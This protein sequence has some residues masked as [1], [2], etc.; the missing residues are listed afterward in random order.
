M[1][2]VIPGDASFPGATWRGSLPACARCSWSATGRLRRTPSAA[3]LRAR[4]PP[5][6]APARP[7]RDSV[8]AAACAVLCLSPLPLLPE[9]LARLAGMR[10][11]FGTGSVAQ[12]VLVG[13]HGAALIGLWSAELLARVR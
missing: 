7:A 2:S 13:P 6:A 9:L 8:E 4:S 10:A 3:A 1:A 11:D 5:P 12:L